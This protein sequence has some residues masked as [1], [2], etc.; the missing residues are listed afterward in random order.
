MT[1]PDDEALAR[2]IR[3]TAS[4]HALKQIGDIVAKERKTEARV[5]QLLRSVLR[6]GWLILLLLT[7]LAAHLMGVF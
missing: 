7:G 6:Y 4:I 3:R 5:N 1:T 2:N